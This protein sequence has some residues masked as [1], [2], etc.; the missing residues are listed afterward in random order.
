METEP[1]VVMGTVG[2]MSPEQVRGSAADPR[3]DIFAFGAI[4]YEMLTR[5]RAFQK[6]TSAETMSAILND[7]P[8]SISQIVPNVPPALHRVVQRC[9]EKNLEQRFQSASDLAFALEALSDSGS[10][11]GIAVLQTQRRRVYWWATVAVILIVSA[12]VAVLYLARSPKVPITPTLTRLTWDSGLTTD[13][14][15]S[16]EG[17]LLAYASDRSGEGHLDIYVQQVGGGEPLRLTHGLGDRPGDNR[18][19]VFSPDGTTI[20]FDSADG[21]I[22]LVPTLGGTPRKLVAEGQGAR[23]SPDGKSIAYWVGGAGGVALNIPGAARMYVVDSSGGVP[24][25]VRSDFAGALFPT[26]TTD[27]RHLLFLG[28]PD[29]SKQETADWW[30]TPLGSGHQWQKRA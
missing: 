4:L 10:S 18:E 13:P 5:K 30:V 22:Y 14:A 24:K 19:P 11:S 3:A 20:A 27:G 21:W 8:A 7:E 17:K 16:S 29:A 15:L 12:L 1:G 9:L 25:Q 28:N 2:Y 23:F 26:W 6:P